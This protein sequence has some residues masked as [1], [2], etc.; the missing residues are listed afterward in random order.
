MAIAFGAVALAGFFK[1]SR[2]PFTPSPAALLL[3]FA[4]EAVV[5]GGLGSLWGTLLG[6]IVLGVAQNV[7]NQ[8]WIGIGVLV[9][10]LI[11]LAVLAFRPHGLLGTRGADMT[12]T[13]TARS[14]RGSLADS[15]S[16]TIGT[17]LFAA[18]TIAARRCCRGGGARPRSS[19][20]SRC[21]TYLSLAQLWNLLAGYA[22]LVS[23]GQQGFVGVG[24]YATF[25]FAERNGID[26]WVSLVLAGLFVAALSV[27]VAL[28]AVPAGGRLLRDRHVGDRRGV[29]A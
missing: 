25:I 17:S 7:G 2:T 19:R 16:A 9:G 26:P 13:D 3:L 5:I 4:F 1:G 12:T 27:P 21:S 20:S 10:H 15:R 18:T 11:F 22:G 28:F 6:G 8:Q 14:R 29:P 23:V 24:A